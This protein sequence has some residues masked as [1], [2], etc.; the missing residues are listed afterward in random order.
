MVICIKAD[1]FSGLYVS[2]ENANIRVLSV[3]P[4]YRTG[5]KINNYEI[6]SFENDETG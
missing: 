2:C 4:G 3:I 1:N 5:Y 6:S